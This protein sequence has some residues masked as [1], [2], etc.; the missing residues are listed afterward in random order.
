MLRY[1]NNLMLFVTVFCTAKIAQA[2]EFGLGSDDLRKL[3][4]YACCSIGLIV[5][6]ILIYSLVKFRKS[7]DVR[8]EHFHKAL[9]LELFWAS[10]PFF[11]L[12]A[13]LLPMWN[14]L[15]R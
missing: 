10:L 15:L 7:K 3:G 5:Y 9:S 8:A 1:F 2:S 6:F 12:L 13:L 4:F 11:I 14:V